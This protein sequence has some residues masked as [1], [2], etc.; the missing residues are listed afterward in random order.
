MH[1]N[2][3][4]NSE[5]IRKP[6]TSITLLDSN[7]ITDAKRATCAARVAN[8]LLL[9]TTNGLFAINF[10]DRSKVTNI[11]DLRKVYFHIPIAMY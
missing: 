2:C 4:T 11:S 10:R 8:T 6:L 5:P 1:Y 9:G 7:E 3:A